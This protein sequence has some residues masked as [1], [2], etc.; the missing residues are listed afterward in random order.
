M[1]R[2]FALVCLSLLEPQRRGRRGALARFVLPQRP[3]FPCKL[4]SDRP[5][6]FL[7]GFG[8]ELL[9]PILMLSLLRRLCPTQR[10]AV[11]L[12]VVIHGETRA[13]LRFAQLA[14]FIGF[15]PS[16]RMPSAAISYTPALN[17]GVIS[18]AIEIDDLGIVPGAAVLIE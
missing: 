6:S 13:I 4:L 5:V 8:V 10:V 16:G 12:L 2:A 18:A 9:R 17:P 3:P 14:P 11:A 1:P 15:R 7:A